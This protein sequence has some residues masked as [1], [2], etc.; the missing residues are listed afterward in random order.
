MIGDRQT[1][2]DCA[3]QA[4]VR[5]ILVGGDV[6]DH[7]DPVARDLTAAARIIL[8]GTVARPVRRNSAILSS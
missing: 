5:P 1:D 3:E 7:F 8:G 2:V 4:N 6:A